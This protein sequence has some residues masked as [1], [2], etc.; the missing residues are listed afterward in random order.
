VFHSDGLLTILLIPIKIRIND[1]NPVSVNY[2]DIEQNENNCTIFPM[3]VLIHSDNA[4]GIDNQKECVF[5]NFLPKHLK[6]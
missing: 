3:T 5:A 1:I 2:P 4:V 6:T